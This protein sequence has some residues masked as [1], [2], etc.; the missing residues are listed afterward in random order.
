MKHKMKT[1]TKTRKSVRFYNDVMVKHTIHVNNYTVQEKEVCWFTQTEYDSIKKKMFMTLD[2]MEFMTNSSDSNSNRSNM[3]DD[4][5]N[6]ANCTRGLENLSSKEGGMKQSTLI[7]RR[8]AI[9]AVLDEQDLQY[10]RAYRDHQESYHRNYA[11]KMISSK[12]NTNYYDNDKIR[13]LYRNQ[14]RS[15]ESIAY[16]MGRIDS[17][18]V[19]IETLVADAD[20]D[21]DAFSCVAD[22]STAMATDEMVTIINANT[23]A[24]AN[25]NAAANNNN[26]KGNITTNLF[27]RAEKRWSFK[28]NNKNTTSNA[29][30]LVQ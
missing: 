5:C 6:N 21:A 11:F 8:N 25:A 15:S 27:R 14:T 16:S 10:D 1:K 18:T 9:W 2:L 4:Y 20:A 3:F 13:D 29:V 12:S 17:E 23:N 22:T 30:I 28:C 7:R 26:R 19:A 24:N